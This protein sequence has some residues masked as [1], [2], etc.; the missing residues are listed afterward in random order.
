M[1]CSK[2][3]TFDRNIDSFS[4]LLHWEIMGILYILTEK[5]S[6]KYDIM[7]LFLFRLRI[8]IIKNQSILV[9]VHYVSTS[10][11]TSQSSS[12]I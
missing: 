3:G 2:C 1:N 5:C 7:F 12:A 9:Y 10:Q 11:F 8:W 4:R 6:A